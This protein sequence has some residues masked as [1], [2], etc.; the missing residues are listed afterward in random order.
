MRRPIN[1]LT[2]LA[3]ATILAI[4][5][6]FAQYQ[7]APRMLP[8][9]EVERVVAPVALY[10][11]PLLAQ[12]LV[13]S[14]YPEHIREA[15]LWADQHSYLRADDLALAASQDH[16]PW[17]VSV[18]ALIPFPSIL[19]ALNHDMAWTTELGN[20]V[21]AQRADVMDA[22]QRLRRQAVNLGY[23]KSN[24]QIRIINANSR[25][26]EIQPDSPGLLY[27]PYYDPAV[28]FTPRGSGGLFNRNGI[29]FAPGVPLSG[30]F[31]VWGWGSGGPHFG[32]NTHTLI[33][34]RGEWNR[35]WSNRQMY[36]H[37]Y[38]KPIDRSAAAAHA[39]E[40]HRLLQRDEEFYRR[41][42]EQ[43]SDPRGNGLGH[44]NQE[45]QGPNRP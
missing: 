40:Q 16:L 24:R 38:A 45:Q 1:N 25:F 27:V 11:D 35:T 4:A 8:I 10:P 23:L 26:I 21:L 30:A 13:A 18:Q 14:T 31:A 41:Q 28:V 37:P 20:A 29:S 33:I 15:A 5:P 19:D 43:Q 2:L 7:Q 42:R 17:D 3:A 9:G 36:Q 12:V 32:W 22:I 44:I 6:A 34:D 39:E